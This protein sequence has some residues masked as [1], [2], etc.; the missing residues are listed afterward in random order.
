MRKNHKVYLKNSGWKFPK[1]AEGNVDK[2]KGSQIRGTQKMPTEYIIT[3][4]SKDK[5]RILKAAREKQFVTQKGNLIRLSKAFSETL[6]A[7]RE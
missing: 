4:L 2:T 7:R 5:D 3:A 6:Q 1:S